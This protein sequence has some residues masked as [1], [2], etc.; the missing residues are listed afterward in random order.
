MR[1]RLASLE[2]SLGSGMFLRDAVERL[3]DGFGFGDFCH[4][5]ARFFNDGFSVGEQLVGSD[6]GGDDVLEFLRVLLFSEPPIGGVLR[7]LRVQPG[8][9]V[10]EGCEGAGGGAVVIGLEFGRTVG[11]AASRPPEQILPS[12]SSCATRFQTSGASMR[13]ARAWSRTVD[14]FWRRAMMSR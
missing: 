2:V 4:P 11:C 6:A 14:T 13:F 12:F 7:E 9:E 5:G 8:V 1:S 10:A 3:L